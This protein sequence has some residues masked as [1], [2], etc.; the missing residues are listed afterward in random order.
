MINRIRVSI[1]VRVNV[2]PFTITGRRYSEP[3]L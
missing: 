3:S 1:M 2:K